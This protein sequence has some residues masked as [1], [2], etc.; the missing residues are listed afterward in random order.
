M[1][2]P[3]HPLA[4]AVLSLACLGAAPAWAAAKVAFVSGKGTDVGDCL[5]PAMPCRTFQYASRQIPTFG[6]VKALDPAGYG[7]I[8]ILD[9]IT[10]TGVEGA[11]IN[12]TSGDHITINLGR[13]DTYVTLSHLTLDG[14]LSAQNGI[15]LN[16]GASLTID[17]CTIRNFLGRGIILQ[18][19]G[20]TKFQI[21]DTI[22]S[23]NVHD[24]IF[25]TTQGTGS[26]QGIL[27]H[28]VINKNR[29]E[30]VVVGTKT[31]VTSVQSVAFGNGLDGFAVSGGAV[32][33]LHHSVAAR[34]G[35]CGVVNFFN[36]TTFSA[37]NNLLYFNG[38][39]TNVC[40]SGSL[41][42]DGKL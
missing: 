2:K 40:G 1:F 42:L 13:R 6:E 27:D 9:S 15:V 8:T 21:A 28:V 10:L 23:D 30:G 14:G 3:L 39:N 22:V 17:H 19:A 35:A 33:R 11:S 7:N 12:S 29:G 37:G 5:S 34:N 31:D 24:G 18:P 16:A 41:I 4:G 26:A 36:G 32:L 25:I 20:A 38:N